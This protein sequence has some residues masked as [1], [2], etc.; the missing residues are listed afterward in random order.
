[1][2]LTKIRTTLGQRLVQDLS[3]SI[4]SV[5]DVGFE[6][7]FTATVTI[8]KPFIK[9]QPQSMK[10]S[11]KR[12]HISN[13]LELKLSNQQRC[14]NSRLHLRLTRPRSSA[15]IHPKRPS[16]TPPQRS[17]RGRAAGHKQHLLTLFTVKLIFNLLL[18]SLCVFCYIM[19]TFCGL[20]SNT[21][22]MACHGG[23]RMPPFR[24]QRHAKFIVRNF[25]PINP[26]HHM[27]TRGLSLRPDFGLHATFRRG[28]YLSEFDDRSDRS[29]FWV[30]KYKYFI[31]TLKAV[32]VFLSE[33]PGQLKYIE[34]PSFQSTL[35]TAALTLV[36]VS[37]LIVALSS[38]DAVLAYLL[39]HF[40]RR[41]G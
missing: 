34:W 40:L 19:A 22:V 12:N 29:S 6:Q 1:M 3:S 23:W 9:I 15:W 2:P 16:S 11:T 31:R 18:C 28:G 26:V 14:K 8:S 32:L 7:D 30:E 38:V 25:T 27:N 24:I 33:Q 10:R 37:V 36:L 39:A 4:Y 20:V 13:Q 5:P 41:S 21:S 35:K 17:A